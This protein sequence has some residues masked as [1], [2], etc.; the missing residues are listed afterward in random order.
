M[1]DDR[2]NLARTS[3]VRERGQL[4]VPLEVRRAL[5]WPEGEV[6]VRVT[7]L[8]KEDGFKV[9]RI[10]LSQE[11]AP[12]RRPTSREWQEIR[13]TMRRIGRSGKA[14]DLTEFLIKDRESH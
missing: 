8:P 11:P 6:L 4:T 12:K 9:E 3:R 10:L 2:E 14:V 13:E 1:E 5:A 7:A